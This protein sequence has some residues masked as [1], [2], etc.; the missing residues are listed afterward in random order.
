VPADGD[1]RWDGCISTVPPPDRFQQEI[2]DALG[3]PVAFVC[4]ALTR[5]SR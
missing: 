2:A 1:F 3:R 5:A 4:R